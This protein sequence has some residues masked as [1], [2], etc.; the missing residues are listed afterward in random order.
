MATGLQGT[1]AL[2]QTPIN[3]PQ[4]T[5][6]VTFLS[7]HTCMTARLA[8]L[9][10]TMMSFDSRLEFSSVYLVPWNAVNYKSNVSDGSR[11]DTV[12]W[13]LQPHGL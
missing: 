1:E 8:V 10:E 12:L 6:K 13:T 9:K 7:K 3:R 2:T 11:V 4:L 5:V